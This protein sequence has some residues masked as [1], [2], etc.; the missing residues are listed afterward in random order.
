MLNHRLQHLGGGNHRLA[1]LHSSADN[2]FL[3]RRHAFR[4]KLDAQIPA[5]YHHYISRSDNR[6]EIFDRLRFFKLGYR[7]DRHIGPLQKL[8]QLDDIRRL[9]HKGQRD[10]VHLVRNAKLQILAVLLR[11]R[12]HAQIRAGQINTRPFAQA[13]PVEDFA[14]DLRALYP[15]HHQ[16]QQPVRKQDLVAYLD[17]PRQW[18]VRSRNSA[19]VAN[20]LLGGNRKRLPRLQSHRP[21]RQA[22]GADLRSLQILQDRHRPIHFF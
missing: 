7:S 8:L 14:L 17:I 3:H 5:R 4:R 10:K 15:P 12:G 18:L 13:P 11:H 9:A 16:P 20:D 19:C 22:P 6:V 1:G 2:A 21:V